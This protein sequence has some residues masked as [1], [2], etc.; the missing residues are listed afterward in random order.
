MRNNKLVIIAPSYNEEEIIEYSIEQLLLVL[1]IM[2][3]DG[4]IAHNSKIC[5]V[6]D[7]STD[8]TKEI[9]ESHC[10]D[11]KIALIN[12]SRNCGQQNAILAG[13]NSVDADIYVTIDVDLQDDPMLIIEMVKKYF[14]GYDIVYGCRKKRET[15]SFFKKNTALLF[16]KFMNLIGINIRQNHS[17]F[18]LLSKF[19]VEKLKEYKE[20]TIFL[21]GIVQNIGLKSCNLYY[22]GLDRLAGKTKYSFLKLL[23]LAWCAITSFSL[24][25]LRLI[26]VVGLFTSLLSLLVIIYAIISYVKHYS[27]PGWTSII[28]TVAFF[29][30][31]IIMSLGIIGEY[32]SKV[33][34]EV[35]NRPLYQIS[36]TVNLNEG[37]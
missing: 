28:M 11:S 19:S 25:P 32:L 3:D 4:L 26:T 31:I 1:N 21:R 33:L 20:K 34:I 13:L 17:E 14:E 27:I 16:Y 18:R 9:I 23:E 37:L 35:K 15:D 30:G 24:L 7:G 5:F 12:L 8:K 6:N 29:S 10:E 36:D 2:I 22:D